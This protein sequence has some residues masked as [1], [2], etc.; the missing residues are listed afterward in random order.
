MA[1]NH[2]QRDG[3]NAATPAGPCPYDAASGTI[4][5]LGFFPSGGP[6]P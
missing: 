6:V 4:R 2:G 1:W 5:D 3:R